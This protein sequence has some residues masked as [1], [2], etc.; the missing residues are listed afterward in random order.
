[1]LGKN[2]TAELRVISTDD[3][4]TKE[5]ANGHHNDQKVLFLAPGGVRGKH[6]HRQFHKKLPEHWQCSAR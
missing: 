3:K 2:M 1:M 4:I 5:Q 6:D